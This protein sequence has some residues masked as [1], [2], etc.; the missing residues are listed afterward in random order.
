[1]PSSPGGVAAGVHP[2]KSAA[3]RTDNEN[4][5]TEFRLKLFTPT[6]FI[7]IS[8]FWSIQPTLGNDREYK[9]ISHSSRGP[10]G[11]NETG[12]DTSVRVTYFVRPKAI[13][14]RGRPHTLGPCR[15]IFRPTHRYIGF[16]RPVAS[17]EAFFE[18]A[19]TSKAHRFVEGN[20]ALI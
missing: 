11:P 12:L 7:L 20:L 10:R 16:E 17:A 15:L 6:P 14:A 19:F 8:P 2:A 18:N 3:E 5:R 1:M 13:R 4:A 9:R